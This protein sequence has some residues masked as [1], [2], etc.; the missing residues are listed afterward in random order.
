MGYPFYG[1]RYI[2]KITISSATTQIDEH[3]FY[4]CNALKELTVPFIG[5]ED[6]ADSRMKEHREKGSDT[7][8]YQHSS[9]FVSWFVNYASWDSWPKQLNNHYTSGSTE[10]TQIASDGNSYIG[11]IPDSLKII[12]ITGGTAIG[13]GAL[14]NLTK[15]TTINLPST[16]TTIKA[17]AFKGDSNLTEITIPSD[18]SEIGDAAFEGCTNCCNQ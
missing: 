9:L 10:T 15:V 13:V 6:T 14:S 1:A 12:N 2:E 18:V 4:G 5:R 8:P 3:T 11:Y 16:L 7:D 17:N